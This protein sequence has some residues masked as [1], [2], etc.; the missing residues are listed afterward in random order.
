LYNT[1]RTNGNWVTM[2]QFKEE[3][4]TT[5]GKRNSTDKTGTRG[6]YSVSGYWFLQGYELDTGNVNDGFN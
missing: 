1:F 2:K 3:V 5:L 4:T 6:V